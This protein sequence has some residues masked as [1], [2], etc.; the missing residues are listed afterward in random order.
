[1]LLV[2]GLWMASTSAPGWAATVGTALR[3]RR[4]QEVYNASCIGCHLGP[5]GGTIDDYPPR[6]NANGHTW[7][8]PDCLIA[9]V[10]RDGISERSALAPPDAPLMPAF[11]D[12]LSPDDIDAVIAY[13]KTLW[14]PE[15][16]SVQ[17]SFTRE[18]CF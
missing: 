17:A 15:Q 6:H 14:T 10:T 4:G 1:M 9:R 12:R 18:M 3:E 11:R 2:F 5:T 8:H 16:R 7:H 13:I